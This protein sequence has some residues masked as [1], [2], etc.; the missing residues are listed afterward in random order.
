MRTTAYLKA[1]MEVCGITIT[2]L[3]TTGNHFIGGTTVVLT[4]ACKKS[5]SCFR[6][7]ENVTRRASMYAYSNKI[8][9]MQLIYSSP[10]WI[11]LS[12]AIVFVFF[13]KCVR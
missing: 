2:G 7:K 10:V 12:L 11:P 1:I 3:G 13:R 8:N 4:V 9:E 6:L 5:V